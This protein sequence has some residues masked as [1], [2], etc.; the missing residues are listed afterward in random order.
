FIVQQALVLCQIAL[1]PA[2][3]AMFLIRSLAGCAGQFFL[4]LV[5]VTLWPL[6]WAISSLMTHALLDLAAQD[7]GQ[8][9]D[10][11]QGTGF[12][13]ILSLWILLST[14]GAPLIIWKLL[15]G[16]ATAGEALFGSVSAGLSQGA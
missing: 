9:V 1:A 2:F 10:Y 8:V 12:V 11:F 4:R 14:I 16:A 7:D 15:S 5:A 13:L 6:G 3:A